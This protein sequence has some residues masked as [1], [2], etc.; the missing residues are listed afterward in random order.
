[1]HSSIKKYWLFSSILYL[2]LLLLDTFLAD[3]E[4]SFNFE[5][6]S[7]ILSIPFGYLALEVLNFTALYLF[8]CRKNGTKL[9]TLNM[10]LSLFR[11]VV[12]LLAFWFW[13]QV[14]ATYQEYPERNFVTDMSLSVVYFLVTAQWFFFS[15]KLRRE[16]KIIRKN[17]I[18][19]QVMSLPECQA[20]IE[21]LK[22]EK[23]VNA[24]SSKYYECLQSYPQIANTFEKI[25]KQREIELKQAN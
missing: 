17:T 23:E 13:E 12:L 4:M 19:S 24:L 14:K 18:L 9:L 16:N 6:F 2:A 22:S 20:L 8:S 3:S 25:Y 11:M 1:M 15:Y 21:E 10:I 5:F 7:L